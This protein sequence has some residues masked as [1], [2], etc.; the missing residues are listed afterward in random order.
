MERKVVSI[1]VVVAIV[2]S[3]FC[4]RNY[5]SIDNQIE[6]LY[7]NATEGIPNAVLYD[8]SEDKVMFEKGID[9]TISV[10]SIVKVLS[11][12][13]GL[14]YLNLEDEFLVGEE[15]DYYLTADAS[16][17]MIKNGQTISF[18]QLLYAVLIPSGSDAAHTLAV[19]TARAMTG[20]PDIPIADAI[21]LFCEEM[22]NYAKE[23][24]CK[25]SFFVNPDGQ[26]D[27]RQYTCISDVVLIAKKALEYDIFRKVVSSPS[28]ELTLVSGEV[29]TWYNTNSMINPDSYYYFEDIKG[30]KTGYTT[31]AG[32]CLL[33]YAERDGKQ[34]LCLVCNCKNESRR[35][36]I[37]SKLMEIGFFAE[38]IKK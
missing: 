37:T 30:I 12:C 23:L 4:A 27:E 15:V 21:V 6:N 36:S 19:N 31:A 24:G 38:S 13:V 18:E 26:D 20:N 10:G 11:V 2:V 7:N 25:N 34:L 16:R 5:M 35:Y 17:S 1:I 8:L 22:N 9:K 14:K 32:F 3:F 28:V 33:S 29:Y